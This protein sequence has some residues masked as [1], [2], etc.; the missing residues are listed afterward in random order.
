[1]AVS[2]IQ[3]SDLHLV[4]DPAGL[5]RGVPPAD[6]LRELLE[7][8]REQLSNAD[9]IVIT[10]DLAQDEQPATYLLLAELLAEH[11]PRCRF[12]L[13]NHDSRAGLRA[14]FAEQFA[15]VAGAAVWEDRVGD[16]RLLA[17]DSHVP[18]ESFGR[19]ATGVWPWLRGCLQADPTTPTLICVHH[20]P[21][22]V[23][24][25]WLDTINLHGGEALARC[26]RQWPCVRGIVTG[27]IHQARATVWQGWPLWTCPSTAFQFAAGQPE[28][29]MDHHPPGWRSFTLD[30]SQVETRV[31]YLPQLRHRADDF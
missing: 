7:G 27:H 19:L 29:T 31:H 28:P 9:R 23:G 24:S 21:L 17:L 26:L 1:M 11:L 15:P 6:C 5:V 20:P 22:E 8:A 10:G 4:A 16:S 14:A 25:P 18:G 2:L 30:G 3:L 12:L 13:G